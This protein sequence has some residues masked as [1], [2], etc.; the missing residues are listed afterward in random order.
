MKIAFQGTLLMFSLI[1]GTVFPFISSSIA[2][3]CCLT[4]H[5]R[6]W[7]N[8]FWGF[9]FGVG[10]FIVGLFADIRSPFAHDAEKKIRCHI[11]LATAISLIVI[12]PSAWTT[13]RY[14]PPGPT[15]CRPSISNALLPIT[16]GP[17][18]S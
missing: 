18:Q 3:S 5:Y 9:V 13:F 11:V 15:Y 4:G 7:I 16:V 14:P 1:A 8:P 2:H 6:E 12:L 10:W 17:C